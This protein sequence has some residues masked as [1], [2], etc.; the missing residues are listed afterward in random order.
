MPGATLLHPFDS[1]DVMRSHP[2]LEQPT[3]TNM[4][5]AL[6]I[7][8]RSIM[9]AVGPC[10]RERHIAPRALAR[11]RAPRALAQ[12]A[13]SRTALSHTRVLAHRVLRT[14]SSLSQK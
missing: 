12:R 1:S 9:K 3:R 6:M 14:A 5:D 2:R 8:T 4:Y 10:P 13:S 11:S 7:P